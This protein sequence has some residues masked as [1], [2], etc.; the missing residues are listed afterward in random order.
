MAEKMYVS[1]RWVC[2]RFEISH[3]TLRSIVEQ[4][5]DDR[6]G[7]FRLPGQKHFR[8][9]RVLVEKELCGAKAEG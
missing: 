9:T 1:A 5:G 6:L 8:F 2:D 4:I 7:R 3:H